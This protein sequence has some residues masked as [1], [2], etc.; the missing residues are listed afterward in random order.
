MAPIQTIRE[1][2]QS[3]EER[4]EFQAEVKQLLDIVIHSLYTNKEIFIRE[5]VSNASDALEKLRYI[6]LTEKD[7]FDDNLPLEIDISTDQKTNTITIRDF[8]IGM[9]RKEL[10]ENLG[11]IAHSGSRAFLRAVQG[12][13][14]I[15][16][17]L[18]GQFGVGFYSVFIVAKSVKVY[19][20]HWSKNGEHLLWMSDGSSSYQIETVEGQRRGCKIVIELKDDCK[21]FSERDRVKQVLTRYSGFVQFPIKLDGEQ[22]NT[23]QAVWMRNKNEI[24]DEE[25]NEF[26]K[27]QANAYDEPMYRVHFNSDAPLTI[28]SLLFIPHENPEHWGFGRVKPGVGLYCRKILIDSKPEGL[29]P[30]W[31]RFTKGVID[32]ADLPL[33]ISRETIQDSM[34]IH[35]LNRVITNRLLKFLEEE[36][37]KQPEKY[38]EFY[39]KFGLFLKEGV[40]TDFTHREQLAKLLRFESSSIEKGKVTSLSQYHS[41]MAQ[42]QKEIYYLFSSNRESVEKNPYLEAFRAHGVEVLFVYEPIDEFALSSIGEF[43]DRKLVSADSSDIELEDLT[44]NSEEEGLSD[45]EAKTL[46]EWI[47]DTLVEKVNE[48]SISKRLLDSP[49][50]VLNADKFMTPSMRRIMKSVHREGNMK[51]S[52]HLEINSRHG[53]IRKL[54]RLKDKDAD[55]AKLVVEQLLDNTLMVAGFLEDQRSMVERLYKILDRISEK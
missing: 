16:D 15:S 10:I 11:T 8:G 40:A 24:K 3:F 32:S 31:L 54:A 30:D 34:L 26:Y 1:M 52:F 13:D 9:T 2:T 46:C 37:E 47:K 44:I 42:G 18:I 27:F 36:A 25:Y 12:S 33:N 6:Q 4:Y 50:I 48:V 21:E 55:L 41:R 23:V 51:Q 22:V 35:K 29:L 7:I 38:E 19:T 53:L 43:G 20:H 28:N 39:K 45:Q 5:L 49:A 17:S 14:Q